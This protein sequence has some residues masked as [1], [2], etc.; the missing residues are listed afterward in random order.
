MGWLISTKGT[1]TLKGNTS[2]FYMVYPLKI[3]QG[4]VD[5]HYYMFYNIWRICNSRIG[6][7][8]GGKF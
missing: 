7:P 8:M 1:H 6:L 4:V 5:Y 3:F 2:R